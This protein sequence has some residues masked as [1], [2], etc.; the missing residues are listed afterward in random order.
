MPARRVRDIRSDD[1]LPVPGVDG[2]AF[3]VAGDIARRGLEATPKPRNVA[4]RSSGLANVRGL[5]VVL[6]RDSPTSEVATVRR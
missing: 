6:I 2:S 4:L 1:L 3:G 5:I